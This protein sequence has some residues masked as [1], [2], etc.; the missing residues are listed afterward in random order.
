MVIDC[1]MRSLGLEPDAD[2]VRRAYL[3]RENEWA[4][5]AM[6]A[7]A[8]I[9]ALRTE[10]AAKDDELVRLRGLLSIALGELERANDRIIDACGSGAV[11]TRVLHELQRATEVNR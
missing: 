4:A 7:V 3:S 6:S 9:H 11:N 2:K 1:L 8:C 5:A 10:I